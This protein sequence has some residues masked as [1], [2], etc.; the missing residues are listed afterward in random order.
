[1]KSMLVKRSVSIDGRTIQFSI[2]QHFWTSLEE[3]AITLSTTTS[4]LLASIYWASAGANMSSA[5][6][7]YVI[8]HFQMR[9]RGAEE[10]DAQPRHPAHLSAARDA[11]G[12][13]PRWL[14]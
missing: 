4:K 14:H 7:T 13:R 11:D 12:V 6:R 3:I 8:D 2:E 1:M 5:I 10:M 9:I